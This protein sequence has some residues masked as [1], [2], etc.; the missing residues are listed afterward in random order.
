M[1]S[2]SSMLPCQNIKNVSSQ[3][4]TQANEAGKFPK[5]CGD[6]KEIHKYL[7]LFKWFV[8]WNY[9]LNNSTVAYQRFSLYEEKIWELKTDLQ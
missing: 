1:N 2:L 8:K 3:V 4:D 6:A 9:L 5:H 7:G